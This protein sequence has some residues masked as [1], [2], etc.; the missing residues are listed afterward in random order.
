M[1]DATLELLE[2]LNDPAKWVKRVSVPIWKPHE[3]ASRIDGKP[4]KVTDADLE[5]YAANM[6]ALESEGVLGRIT[7]GHTK[8]GK[9]GESQPS[10]LGVYRNPRVGAWGP[11]GQ[12]GV[13][14]D[15][16]FKPETYRIATER[17]YRSAE[18]YT[19]AKTIRGLA[20]L[21]TDPRL[22]MGMTAFESG[23]V[24]EFYAM[25]NSNM[26]DATGT[27]G[28]Q[29]GAAAGAG[30][31]PAVSG[32]YTPEE[33]A[34]Y[35]KCRAYLTE[36]YGLPATWPG[37][38]KK[39]EPEVKPK[40]EE[41]PAP[42]KKPGTEEKPEMNASDKIPEQYEARISGLEKQLADERK[43]RE[44]ERKAADREKCD[45]MARQLAFEGYSLS[46]D[47]KKE[48]VEEL[49]PRDKAGRE[50]YL[51]HARKIYAEHKVPGGPM[52]ELYEGHV[53]GSL[54]DRGGDGLGSVPKGH[55]EALQLMAETP[56]MSYTQAMRK[57]N[58]K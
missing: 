24:P 56:G 14:V 7:D 43:A 9:P 44:D 46:D 40:P 16:Y 22:D 21:V 31:N 25:E 54:P 51:G 42:E 5:D 11:L 58:T 28:E 20:L 37:E 49:L 27:G 52:I 6:R 26:A 4:I 38:A 10:L 17:P 35:E 8:P 33:I 30:A 23:D 34:A 39:P 13:L 50:K 48:I 2:S 15:C 19:K 45:G 1:A 12:K 3:T 32:K 18:A 53:E 55:K 41:T 57:V 29:G 36:T 47:Q